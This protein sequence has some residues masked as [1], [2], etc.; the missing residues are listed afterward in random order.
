MRSRGRE[1]ALRPDQDRRR[2][3]AKPAQHIGNRPGLPGLAA[4]G[5]AAFVAS[6][7]SIDQQR[8][9]HPSRPAALPSFTASRTGG[10]SSRSVCSAASMASRCSRSTR[11][12]SASVRSVSTGRICASAQLNRLLDH[13]IRARLLE[14]RK[15]QPQV[16]DAR[17]LARPL[18][19]A[20][21]VAVLL[22]YRRNAGLELTIPP[23]EH[24]H[25]IAHGQPQDA[26]QVMGL[27]AIDQGCPR[28]RRDR[29]RH[30]GGVSRSWLRAISA[31]NRLCQGP[32]DRACAPTAPADAVRGIMGHARACLCAALPAAF[33]L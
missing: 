21:A 26:R 28:P 20:S 9:R 16:G 12:V 18:A 17:L 2:P 11:T 27:I 10:T 30:E 31:S 3:I 25:G 8:A 5:L 22:V 4:P 19:Q 24:P 6:L 29:G 7:I 23:V 33:A 32:H 1:P 15:Q 13:E 14:R